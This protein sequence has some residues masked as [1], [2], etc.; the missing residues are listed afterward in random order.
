MEKEESVDLS[1][2]EPG[3]GNVDEDTVI[4]RLA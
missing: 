1:Q 2:E 4:Q 3:E